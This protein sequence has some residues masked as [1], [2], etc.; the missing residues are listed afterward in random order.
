M[1]RADE[2][3]HA[4]HRDPGAIHTLMSGLIDYAGLFPPAK[5]DMRTSVENYARYLASGDAWMLGRFICP[6]SRLEEFRTAST[7]LLPQN[8]DDAPWPI[9]AI[10]D[11]DADENLDSVFAFNHEHAKPEHG[12][13][14][15]DAVEIKSPSP[16]AIDDALDLIPEEVFPFFE[17]P[18]LPTPTETGSF[19]APDIRGFVAALAGS[20]AG[21]KIRTGGVSAEMIPAP[22]IV[23]DFLLTC[24]Q[25]DV[26]FKATAGLHHPIRAH[27]PLTYEPGAPMG[28]MHGFLNVFLTAALI[29]SHKLPLESAVAILE[30]TSPE[31]FG[32]GDDQANWKSHGIDTAHL[33]LAR[34]TFCLSYGSCSFTEPTDELRQLGLL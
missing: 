19:H 3:P 31:S 30:D 24:A 14:N 5:L 28:C 2:H 25:A 11:G 34:E 16:E 23:A 7:D 21:A 18:V 22:E 12:L 10:L 17:I 9:S 4:E 20:D 8:P 15:I 13:A 6:V 32:F 26:P 33:A 1:T 27:Y 29:K